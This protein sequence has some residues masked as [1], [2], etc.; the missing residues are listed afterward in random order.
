MSVGIFLNGTGHTKS[1]HRRFVDSSSLRDASMAALLRLSG[2]ADS[3]RFDAAEP[4]RRTTLFAA[5]KEIA[6]LERISK[7]YKNIL[8]LFDHFETFDSIYIIT[9][10]ALGG[11]LLDRICQ[12]GSYYETDAADLIR[13]TLS[14]VGYLHDHGVV[15]RDLKPENLLFYTLESNANLVVA[16]FGLSII[17]ERIGYGKPV[18]MWAIGVI[19]YS[20]LCSYKPFDQDSEVDLIHAIVTA[21]YK[22]TPVEYWE[23]VSPGFRI[24]YE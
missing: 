3:A 17:D 2:R 7:G 19:T 6:I 22:F 5:H 9:D 10:L 13:A 24:S 16:D 11:Q 21:D 20:L 15:H 1:M 4:T 12:R 18:D 14:A 23:D 8:T